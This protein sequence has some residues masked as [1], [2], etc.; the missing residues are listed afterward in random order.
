M[1]K[2]CIERTIRFASIAVANLDALL[3]GNANDT[4]DVHSVLRSALDGLR[5]HLPA[6]TDAFTSEMRT[7]ILR[8][9]HCAQIDGS[10]RIREV[11]EVV[12]AI[13]VALEALLENLTTIE[14]SA[15]DALASWTAAGSKPND[16]EQDGADAEM[17]DATG[18]MDT[19]EW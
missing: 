13:K 12:V 4:S 3:Q 2:G 6:V 5:D 8:L 19:F 16:N 14:R 10:M 1:A 15:D 9:A 11:R 17:A 18:D 7:R